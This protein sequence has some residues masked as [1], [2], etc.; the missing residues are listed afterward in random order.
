MV[1]EVAS[2]ADSPLPGVGRS[3]TS[4]S[5]FTIQQSTL[6]DQSLV[7]NDAASVQSFE[8]AISN[9]TTGS[10]PISQQAASTSNESTTSSNPQWKR[11]WKGSLLAIKFQ[12]ALMTI[13]ASAIAIMT[14]SYLRP[15]YHLASWSAKQQF[16][17]DCRTTNNRTGQLLSPECAKALNGYMR[18]PTLSRRAAGG[19]LFPPEPD[20]QAMPTSGTLILYT[21]E[22]AIF[23]GTISTGRV[24]QYCP[25]I[26]FPTFLAS[27]VVGL[28][29]SPLISLAHACVREGAF[30]DNIRSLGNG[31]Y[32]CSHTTVSFVLVVPIALCI[33]CFG[34]THKLVTFAAL[35]S[36]PIALL[37][38]SQS[39]V[40]A[41]LMSI[42]PLAIFELTTHWKH[43]WGCSCRATRHKRHPVSFA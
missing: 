33:S 40:W 31:D 16:R 11:F 30:L 15:Q 6:D 20:N 32:S 9:I 17:D 34:R 8:T 27:M 36:V 29:S 43:D 7:D 14:F 23:I 12:A 26:K 38:Y 1:S 42:L 25:G 19:A 18:P 2:Q 13:V 35:L 5:T 22:A 39:A 24:F 3:D 21:L 28:V 41:I 4:N 37:I 10:A